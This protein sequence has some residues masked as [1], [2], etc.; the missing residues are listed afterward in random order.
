V[1]KSNV[2]DIA[3]EENSVEDMILSN[4]DFMDDGVYMD[5]DTMNHFAANRDSSQVEV[6]E[7]GFGDIH[8]DADQKGKIVIVQANTIMGGVGN[9]DAR[10]LYGAGYRVQLKRH[11]LI[12]FK[13]VKNFTDKVADII[14]HGKIEEI[15][16]CVADHGNKIAIM[17]GANGIGK[18]RLV[19]Q[20]LIKHQD[21]YKH[22]CNFRLNDIVGYEGIGADELFERIVD[23]FPLNS[24][25]GVRV[26]GQSHEAERK[27]RL[28]L[29]QQLN[30]NVVLLIE[31]ARNITNTFMEKVISHGL[32][33]RIIL[34]TNEPCDF[35]EDYSFCKRIS[36]SFDPETEFDAMNTIFSDTLKNDAVGKL[37]Q[38][39]DRKS[40]FDELEYNT[41]LIVFVA[42]ILN[43]TDNAT[44]IIEH[45]KNSNIQSIS[46]KIKDK[47]TIAYRSLFHYV[48]ELIPEIETD[49]D[50]FNTVLL[51]SV[52]GKRKPNF[53]SLK[54]YYGIDKYALMA[55]HDKGILTY[56]VASGEV[57]VSSMLIQVYFEKILSSK[58]DYA[59]LFEIFTKGLINEYKLEHCSTFSDSQNTIELLNFGIS[60]LL[61]NVQANPIEA[62]ILM[63]KD[64]ELV[65]DENKIA[66]AIS[67]AE[68][69][70]ALGDK[71]ASYQILQSVE[72]L[73]VQ[74]LQDNKDQ[75]LSILKSRYKLAGLFFSIDSVEE[76]IYH[77]EDI[78]KSMQLIEDGN[79]QFKGNLYLRLLDLY[80]IKGDIEKFT[81]VAE[82]TISL[83]NANDEYF[84]SLLVLARLLRGPA[85]PTGKSKK[86]LKEVKKHIMAM[87]ENNAVEL[88][89]MFG[90]TFLKEFFAQDTRNSGLDFEGLI[91]YFYKESGF[92]GRIKLILF[93]LKSYRAMGRMVAKFDPKDPSGRFFRYLFN[94]AEVA[95]NEW[96]ESIW[97]L[98]KGMSDRHEH[99]N[100]PYSLVANFQAYV[101]VISRFFEGLIKIDE[102]YANEL[103]MNRML[104]EL[105]NFRNQL[106]LTNIDAARVKG[107]LYSYFTASLG[108][109]DAL[110]HLNEY[111]ADVYAIP[112]NYVLNRVES[113]ENLGDLYMT[114][115][116]KKMDD[117]TRAKLETSKT[118]ITNFY[119]N[120]FAKAKRCYQES[121][122][123]ALKTNINS[124]ARVKIKA[125]SYAEVYME[126][127]ERKVYNCS[128]CKCCYQLALNALDNDDK[129]S[130]KT[131]FKAMLK[132]AQKTMICREEC[133]FERTGKL[134]EKFVALKS[135]DEKIP[136]FLKIA[137]LMLAAYERRKKIPVYGHVAEFGKTAKSDSQY[138]ARVLK[139][140][141]KSMRS[142]KIS[143]K[144]KTFE[145]HHYVWMYFKFTDILDASNIKVFLSSLKKMDKLKHAF[146]KDYYGSENEITRGLPSEIKRSLQDR[147]HGTLDKETDRFNLSYI[148]IFSVLKKY[149]SAFDMSA[150][151]LVKKTTVDVIRNILFPITTTGILKEVSA[152]S[153]QYGLYYSL[154]YKINNLLN[155]SDI[156]VAEDILFAG[157]KEYTNPSYL[158]IINGFYTRISGFDNAELEKNNF[159]RD[160]I[161]K[162]KKEAMNIYYVGT[163][164]AY[165]DG[166]GFER[167]YT[168]AIEWYKKAVE[169]EYGDGY[170]CL[171]N[172]YYYGSGV[173]KN[174]FIAVDYYEKAMAKGHEQAQRTLSIC[175]YYGT[176]V[177]KDLDKSAEL[178]YSMAQNELGVMLYNGKDVEQDYNKAAS[179]FQRAMEQG[180]KKAQ[181]NLAICY[182]NGYG[183][184]KN[185]LKSAELGYSVAQNDMGMCYVNGT[186]VEQNYKSARNWFEKSAVQGNMYAQYNLGFSYHYGQCDAPNPTVAADWY[187]KASAQGHVGAQNKLALLYYYG[188][189]AM[190]D[191]RK[192]VEFA[193]K[194]ATKG[195]VESQDTLGLCYLN[196]QGVVRDTQ[197]ALSWFT[198]AA[199]QGYAPS[200]LS[201]GYHYLNG[202]NEGQDCHEAT[203]WFIKAAEQGNAE[204]QN[205]LGLCYLSG[206]GVD[207]DYE[208]AIEWLEKA[209]QWNMN[210]KIDLGS[211]Y[212]YGIGVEQDYEKAIEHYENPAE[213]GYTI[214][215][216]MLGECNYYGY[217]VEKDLTKA[218]EWFSKAATRND[219]SAQNWMGVC[220]YNGDGIEQSYAKATTQ[221]EAANNTGIT[222]H[223]LPPLF[224]WERLHGN[225]TVHFENGDVYEGAFEKGRRIGK[226]KLVW[227]N[228]DSYEGDFLNGYGNG[229]G[230]F[231][232]VS[233]S[234]EHE[235]DLI[236]GQFHGVGVRTWTNG[237][238]YS[239]EWSNNRIQGNGTFTTVDGY[240]YKGQWAAGKR[241]GKGTAI[242]S[243]GNKYEG[244]WLN[245]HMHGQGAFWAASDEKTQTGIWENSIFIKEIEPT[246]T[247]DVHLSFDIEL[248]EVGHEKIKVIKA[249]RE[250]TGIGLKEAKEMVENIPKLMR[251]GV[252]K[253]DADL[254]AET[255]K[256]IGAII[257]VKPS[258]L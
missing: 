47:R 130:Y 52:I 105:E 92:F 34:L 76:S 10:S 143:D 171:G 129:D 90:Y 29:L 44:G 40:L 166:H 248:T 114:A 131:Y 181:N 84:G 121:S 39:D 132:T 107:T 74:K 79:W 68:L 96:T 218:V 212:Y 135:D 58:N 59:N 100:E 12:E 253:I 207:E 234:W 209:A 45:I 156:C 247:D 85:I 238:K 93:G 88:S 219:K 70:N 177:E 55:L 117:E 191:H 139:R 134:R 229:K 109:T 196:G 168:K 258:G 97:L 60:R 187:S 210:A 235:G 149:N 14:R 83:Y 73:G 148:Y 63:I 69:Y 104:V 35:A 225:D 192:A 214:A 119:N 101:N 51:L 64:S 170:Y 236:N 205:E 233:N 24:E 215:Q 161:E 42:R 11:S 7:R 252:S 110:R 175:Y 226:G 173:H 159:S 254:I 41:Q 75:Y 67:A 189:G 222:H 2:K 182:Y 30:E 228:G 3:V 221:F 257:T 72:L 213:L 31:N 17:H 118:G 113:L 127:K 242:W 103:I 61:P 54:N 227:S 21:L 178:G 255:F 15:R 199:E 202:E 232:S 198:K 230:L 82:E 43:S 6:V 137:G 245:D 216:T 1:D 18:L 123:L 62:V 80:D 46:D 172:C 153:N 86:M 256:E 22:L 27:F 158:A 28:N 163:G 126:L 87:K 165:Y 195:Y 224:E 183:V 5:E 237:S 102:I 184:D 65:S 179:L 241:T 243:N 53:E 211:C 249:I 81:Q 197:K 200:Q 147:I 25:I 112:H 169:Q 115:Y 203:K 16:T 66:I 136:I 26:A 19:R 122:K 50:D 164:N 94:D 38:V 125:G 116:N 220:Y 240:E 231:D 106:L 138:R 239:G 146:L 180:H 162:G 13:N 141:G 57:S 157:I 152:L 142:L 244:E 8:V 98:F 133:L 4:A 167:N 154:L 193:E 77:F 78:V 145:I 174:T 111:E 204:A 250:A 49:S 140:L 33:C 185:L 194:A 99:L 155:S 20:F 23:A 246:P 223:A 176:G 186:S 120:L 56:N 190:Q 95:P 89:N 160:D 37:I 128:F 201:L 208:K 150:S 217:G 36:L 188:A 91:D 71:D 251:A 32:R 124:W 151:K 108:I 144:Q 9:I 48:S 206:I